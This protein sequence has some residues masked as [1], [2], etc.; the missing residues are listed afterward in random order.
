MKDAKRQELHRFIQELFDA[1]I[2]LPPGPAGNLAR[3]IQVPSAVAE[4]GADQESRFQ[5]I[6]ESLQR[7]SEMR[8]KIEELRSQGRDGIVLP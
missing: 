3:A 4:E 5:V 7:L 2:S 1:E 8:I 6:L